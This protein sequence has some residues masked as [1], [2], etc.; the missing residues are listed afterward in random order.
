M[1]I[2]NFPLLILQFILKDI[3]GNIISK[4]YDIRLQRYKHYKTDRFFDPVD[5]NVG[6]PEDCNLEHPVAYNMVHPVDCNMGY[7][8][9]YN[10]GH[11][12]E[13]NAGHPFDYIMWDTL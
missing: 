7:P 1:Y 10:L 4:V 11:P 5:Y 12:V 8:V 9:V 2:S 13:Y 3:P 6:H